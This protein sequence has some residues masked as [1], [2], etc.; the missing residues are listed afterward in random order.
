MFTIFSVYEAPCANAN[1]KMKLVSTKGAPTRCLFPTQDIQPNTELR[2]DYGVNDLPWR[3]KN[4]KRREV[5]KP[6]FEICE[7]YHSIPSNEDDSHSEI[8]MNVGTY[9]QRI[10]HQKQNIGEEHLQSGASVAATSC[11][12]TNTAKNQ[13]EQANSSEGVLAQLIAEKHVNADMSMESIPH[14]LRDTDQKPSTVDLRQQS[15]VLDLIKAEEQAQ[16][17]AKGILD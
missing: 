8:Q 4:T 13:S 14:E 2:Y 11:Q 17:E 3:K 15:Y 9:L 5:Y 1:C 7:R 12:L 16:L 6:S 10:Q